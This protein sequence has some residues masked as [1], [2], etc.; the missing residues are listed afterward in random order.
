M[1][2][3]FAPIWGGAASTRGAFA[4]A[5]RGPSSMTSSTNNAE[6]M[7]RF[8]RAAATTRVRGSTSNEGT[9]VRRP[10]LSFCERTTAQSHLALASIKGRGEVAARRPVRL[11]AS[12]PN[13]CP[14]APHASPPRALLLVELA[15]APSDITPPLR[16]SVD[17]SPIIPLPFHAVV[18]DIPPKRLAED[19]RRQRADAVRRTFVGE[20][21]R[22]DPD[23]QRVS[24]KVPV[25][26]RR[27][28]GRRRRL[29]ERQVGRRGREEA[30][31]ERRGVRRVAVSARAPTAR[32]RVAAS[33]WSLRAVKV[34]KGRRSDGVRC[35]SRLRCAAVV[36][37]RS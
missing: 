30:R 37:E 13:R 26:A 20:E 15:R 17:L 32:A 34:A 21:V 4:T 12:S 35:S 18:D 9:T 14:R 23:V 29:G 27:R 22:L 2:Q 11:A 5:R 10:S 1:S 36:K 19:G 33:W 31:V 25:L 28:R 3:T 8:R 16:G 24:I 7:S 6:A